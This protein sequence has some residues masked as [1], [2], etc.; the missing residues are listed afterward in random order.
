MNSCAGNVD[1]T[2]AQAQARAWTRIRNSTTGHLERDD[3]SDG[4]PAID[5]IRKRKSRENDGSDDIPAIDAIRRRKSRRENDGSDDIPET[6][7]TPMRR[8][9]DRGE[10]DEIPT[11]MRMRPRNLNP[12]MR[13]KSPRRISF[14]PIVVHLVVET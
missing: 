8:I 7:E 4:I 13:A 9:G 5:A 3:G 6:D 2:K 14:L 12:P 11:R 10:I 1:G